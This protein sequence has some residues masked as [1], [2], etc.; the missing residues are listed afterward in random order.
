[1]PTAGASANGE[2][3]SSGVTKLE[4]T[5]Q[6]WSTER[7]KDGQIV[8]INYVLYLADEHE[9]VVEDSRKRRK[10]PF[11]FLLGSTDVIEGI[12]VAVR[13]FGQGER[14]KLRISS[15]FAY[16]ELT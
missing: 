10:Q 5:Y 2:S 11:S 15:D 4:T 6:P 1:M 16:G 13:S 9:T 8:K 14:S 7:P 3:A 12:N